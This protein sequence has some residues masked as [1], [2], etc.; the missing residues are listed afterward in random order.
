MMPSPFPGMD[1]F[2]EDPA[3]FPDL[4]DSLIAYLREALQSRLPQTYYAALGARVWVEFAH[5]TIG[6]DVNV[7]RRDGGTT[8][9]EPADGGVAVAPAVRAKPV[10]VRVPHDERRETF[11]EIYASDGRRLVTSIEVLS[12]ANKTPGEHGQDLYLQKQRE[13]LR[14]QVHLVEIDLLRRGE[15]AT[16]VPRD[17]AVAEAGPFDYHVC[18]HRFDRFQEFVVYPIQLPEPLPEIA[19]PLLPGDQ[20]VV[21]DLQAVFT[22]CYDIG[23]FDRRIDYAARVPGPPLRPDP[24]EWV[25]RLLREKGILPPA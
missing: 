10:V 16:A 23:A 8:S 2:L 20:P 12:P 11:V 25:A 13:L 15:H 19:I 9:G 21:I 22:R 6:P 24:A 18:V 3:V 7:L 1:P 4:H 14:S 17:R 5:R